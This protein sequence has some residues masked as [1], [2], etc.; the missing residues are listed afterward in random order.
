MNSKEVDDSVGNEPDEPFLLA[1]YIPPGY[2]AQ[3]RK[4]I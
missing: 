3:I 1:P 2:F 4:C